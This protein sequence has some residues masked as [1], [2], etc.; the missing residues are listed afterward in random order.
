MKTVP[1]EGAK[2]QHTITSNNDFINPI[3]QKHQEAHAILIKSFGYELKILKNHH[4]N[5]KLKKIVWINIL[6]FSWLF[7][8]FLQLG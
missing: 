4:T 1:R 5:W 2:I 3:S 8:R 6:S 7:D